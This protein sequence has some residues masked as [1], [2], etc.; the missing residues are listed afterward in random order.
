MHTAYIEDDIIHAIN[1]KSA[2]VQ[3][4]RRNKCS[5]I[6]E[7]ETN[8]LV[9]EYRIPYRIRPRTIITH[10][11]RAPLIDGLGQTTWSAT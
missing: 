10:A 3:N 8:C 9:A 6:V 1:M 5:A 2:K 11:H 7:L 4:P